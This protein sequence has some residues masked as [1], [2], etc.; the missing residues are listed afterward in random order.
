MPAK[1]LFSLRSDFYYRMDELQKTMGYSLGPQDTFELQKFT[2]SQATAIFQVIAE[3][4]DLNFDRSFVEEMTKQE[5]AQ[6]DDGLISP[7]DI[8]ILAWVIHGQKTEAKGGFNK[9]AFQKM[10]G[11]EGLLENFLARALVAMTPETRRQAALKVLLALID[12]EN[13][14][15]A[16][17]LS[18]MQIREKL[19]G[20]VALEE[21][22]ES[23]AWLAQSNL[24]LITPAQRN[25]QVG[26]ELAHERLI[27]AV[28]RMAG[29]VFSQADQANQLLERRVNEWLGNERASRYLLDWRE[30]QRI[31]KQKPYLVWGTRQSQKEELLK[32]SQH[33]LQRLAG[34]VIVPM[35]L[36]FAFGAWWQSPWG[37]IYQVKMELISLSK[38]ISDPDVLCEVATAFAEVGDLEQARQSTDAITAGNDKT[39]VLIA[40]AGSAA[41]RGEMDKAMEFLTHTHQN[42][43]VITDSNSNKATLHR[44]V[45][46]SERKL[47]ETDKII[48]FLE[49]ACQIVET[50]TDTSQK[51]FAISEIAVAVAKMGKSD[52]ANELLKQACQ[53]AEAITHDYSKV[54]ALSAIATSAAQIDEKDQAIAFLGHACQI[55]DSMNENFIIRPDNLATIRND[56]TLAYIAIYKSVVKIAEK[57][58]DAKFFEQA[59][60]IFEQAQHRIPIELFNTLTTHTLVVSM[61]KMGKWQEARTTARSNVTNADKAKALAAILSVWAKR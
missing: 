33:R 57:T 2:P 4:A 46:T 8:Q 47:D 9:T 34:L 28:R 23:V 59:Q 49:Q 58:W 56:K 20:T 18:L 16:G 5:L 45:A 40:V 10:G 52:K 3:V 60:H 41:K 39:F 27:P 42:F 17:V 15:R 26:Y 43:K 11:I 30:L 61:A 35:I 29:Q 38:T 12:L 19:A 51:A 53:I 21:M 14:V 1:I 13:N 25:G 50:I 22:S 36:L 31:K 7:V 48:A 55:A 6:R 37:Q 32:Q 24:R 54:F 44:A